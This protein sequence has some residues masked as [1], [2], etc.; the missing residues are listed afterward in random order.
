MKLNLLEVHTPDH[1]FSALPQVELYLETDNQTC[2]ILHELFGCAFKVIRDDVIKLHG[3]T[4]EAISKHPFYR[5]DA[6]FYWHVGFFPSLQNH[7]LEPYLMA[8]YHSGIALLSTM[9]DAKWGFMYMLPERLADK[10]YSCVV[11]IDDI[12]GA[13]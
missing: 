6:P 9:H 2:E 11:E 3:A 13:F 8:N 5:D 4:L 1:Y 12:E 7:A 10:H